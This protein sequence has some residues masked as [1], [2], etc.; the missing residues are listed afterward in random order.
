[1]LENYYDN[2]GLL[3]QWPSKKPL[4]NIILKRIG[5][6][7]VKDKDYTEKEV[8]SIIKNKIGFNDIEMIRRELYNNHILNRL[9]DGSKYWKE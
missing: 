1:M 5:D 2:D 9:K 7:F 6:S 3:K 4:K 8:N